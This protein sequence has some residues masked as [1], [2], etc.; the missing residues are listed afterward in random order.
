M[1]PDYLK[2]TKVVQFIVAIVGLILLFAGLR[3][4]LQEIVLFNFTGIHNYY[5][6]SRRPIFYIIDNSYYAI[7][8]ILYSTLIYLAIK[9]METNDHNKAELNLLKSQI[10]PHFLFNTLNA[11]YVELIDDKPETAKDIHKL[12]E[13]LRY[14]TYDSQKDVVLLKNEI[15]FLKDY[16]HFFNKRFESDFS[17][18]FQVTGNL[19]NQE[20]PSLI[21][22]HFIENLFKHGVVNDKKNPATINIIIH[23]QFIEV[24][25]R[26]KILT[27]D[28]F[29]E[30]GIGTQ[31]VKR[32]LTTLFNTN[33]KL[34]YTKETPYFN[35]Y[36]K[37][38]L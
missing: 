11:F 15:Q 20:I 30:S 26:N 28:K 2:K 32:R 24:S 23:E 1:C 21:L 19:K 4:V 16:I 14:V 37:M 27:S 8:A 12:S 10:S 3:Y 35:T 29:M 5:E 36:L 22:I 31:N 34:V 18:T 38:P 25:T 17:V 13:L 9:F 7:K 6:T 33:Y